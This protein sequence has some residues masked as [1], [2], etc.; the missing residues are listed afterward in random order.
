MVP[1]QK[2]TFFVLLIEKNKLTLFLSTDEHHFSFKTDKNDEIDTQ[3]KYNFT[4]LAHELL[5]FI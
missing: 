4:R 3:F 5:R 1:L 2:I